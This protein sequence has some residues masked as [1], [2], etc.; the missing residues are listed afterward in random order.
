MDTRG[1]TPGKGHPLFQLLWP[2][3]TE[4]IYL[5]TEVVPVID[6]SYGEF[7]KYL[8]GFAHAGVPC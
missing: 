2:P 4:P 5:P 1:R 6:R 8:A 7:I 3:K